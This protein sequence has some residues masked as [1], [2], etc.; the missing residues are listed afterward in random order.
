M[1]ASIQGE[2]PCQSQ[3]SAVWK[4]V[5]AHYLIR[6]YKGVVTCGK[7][8]TNPLVAEVF[9]HTGRVALES[10]LKLVS[11]QY[12]AQIMRT[13]QETRIIGRVLYT[14]EENVYV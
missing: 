13:Q 7:Y 3:C 14:F 11:E 10:S 6:A 9:D 1:V 2:P 12:E 5:S 4:S 8:L